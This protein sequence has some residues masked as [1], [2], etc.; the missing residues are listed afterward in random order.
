MR[1]KLGLALHQA[2]EA[3]K[4]IDQIVDDILLLFKTNGWKQYKP[5][6]PNKVR[7]TDETFW[8]QVR[9]LYTWIDIDQEIAKMKGYQLTEKGKNWKITKGSVINWLGKIPK[10]LS[11]VKYGGNN[12]GP[13]QSASKGSKPIIYETKHGWKKRLPDGSEIDCP[14]P[15]G[16]G[17]DAK[18]IPAREGTDRQD[19]DGAR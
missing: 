13:R 10:P 15:T 17:T 7:V 9:G 18:R 16:A 4:T 3:K 5:R 2:N 12:N 14:P 8:L 6:G 19:A 1:T 11:E